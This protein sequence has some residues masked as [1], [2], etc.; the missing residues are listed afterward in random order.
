MMLQDVDGRPIPHP[1]TADAF[2]AFVSLHSHQHGLNR[3]AANPHKLFSKQFAVV[4][5]DM[6]GSDE[7]VSATLPCFPAGTP[8][9]D[10]FDLFDDHCFPPGNSLYSF[11]SGAYTSAD[12]V[13]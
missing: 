1:Y 6:E 3:P 9:R 2:D 7:K 10:C 5:K 4:R 8:Q 12:R 13:E 11:K